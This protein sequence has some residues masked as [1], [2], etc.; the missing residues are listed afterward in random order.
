MDP[1]DVKA[2]TVAPSHLDTGAV[3]NRANLRIVEFPK[4]KPKRTDAQHV[5]RFFR[6]V[7]AEI[8]SGELHPNG[9]MVIIQEQEGNVHR[10][11][12]LLSNISIVEAIGLCTMA[13][14]DMREEPP[15]EIDWNDG[16]EDE[17]SDGG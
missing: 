14:G 11:S 16:E 2:P 9:A 17:D 10:L 5:A 7:I 8:E 13:A 1:S 3:P 6:K 12:H 4:P 15:T